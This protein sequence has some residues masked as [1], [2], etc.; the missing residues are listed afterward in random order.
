MQG[1]GA[2]MIRIYRQEQGLALRSQR[3]EDGG[4]K[5]ARSKEAESGA[6]K[7]EVEA[8]ERSRRGAESEAPEAE[9]EVPGRR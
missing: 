3:A 1:T 7:A 2:E 6:L 5:G 4:S 8:P 9:D